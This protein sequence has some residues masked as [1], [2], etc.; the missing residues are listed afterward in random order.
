MRGYEERGGGHEA[1]ALSEDVL[2]LLE[3]EVR[4]AGK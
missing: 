4:V 1:N 3:G 2:I